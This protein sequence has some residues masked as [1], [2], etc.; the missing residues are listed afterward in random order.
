V[1]IGDLQVVRYRRSDRERVF[2]FLREA[3]P[4]AHGERL[5]RQWEWKYEANPF[6]PDGEPYLLLLQ[7]GVRLAGI[8][9]RLFFRGT[10]DGQPCWVHHGCDLALHPA[11]RGRGLMARLTVYDEIESEIHFSWQNEASYHAAQRDQTAG[12]PFKPLIRL[13]DVAYVS[14]V[15]PGNRWPGRAMASL[16]GSVARRWTHSPRWRADSDLA[17]SRADSFDERFD[18]LWQRS[19]GDYP[20]MIARD[21][22]YLSWRFTQRPDASYTVVAATRADEVVGYAVTRH[23]DREGERWGYLV[24]FL[25]RDRD[26]SVF[27]ALVEESIRGLRRERA[28]AVGCRFAVEPYRR[29]LYRQGFVPLA[30]G[31]KGYIRVRARLAG[32]TP[33]DLD[34]GDWF[35]TMG[36]GDLETSL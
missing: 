2:A 17:V 5:I 12:V 26:P 11:Y 18:R 31:P 20:V 8:Y 4:P 15:V 32:P 6:H 14:R 7:D 13:L 24:D 9:G 36:D 21:R 35:L 10:I 22:R 30:W 25:V 19:C 34:V 27:G 28:V 23:L 1:V 16:I 3:F 29:M 33:R